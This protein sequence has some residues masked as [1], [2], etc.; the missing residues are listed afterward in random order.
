L[1]N[2]SDLREELSEVKEQIPV[3]AEPPD[4][5]Q[6][7]VTQEFIID[8][9]TVNPEGVLAWARFSNG[10]EQLVPTE[11]ISVDASPGTVIGAGE[12]V[13]AIE[14]YPIGNTS[15]S[16]VQFRVDLATSEGVTSD[17]SP[18]ADNPQ[19]DSDAPGLQAIDMSTLVPGPDESVSAELLPE[20]AARFRNVTGATVFGPD[21]TVLNSTIS[22]GDTVRFDTAG[23]GVYNVQTRYADTE[24]NTYEVPVTVQASS[25]SRTTGPTIRLAAG[26]AAGRYAVVGDGLVSG[27]VYT[28][29]TRGEL[30]VTATVS[31]GAPSTIHLW[32]QEV[33]IPPS[34]SLTFETVDTSGQAVDEGISVIM[35]APSLPEDALVWV[36]TESGNLEPLPEDG[37][38]YGS[39]TLQENQTLYQVRATSGSVTVQQSAN[40]G[41][42]ERIQYSVETALNGLPFL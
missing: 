37:N 17:T 31:D 20:D 1:E 8:G 42:I 32:A 28:E 18:V 30:G 23:A 22:D 2:I 5:G 25:T 3:D 11:Y 33:D 26:P 39:E 24:S 34:G 9:A 36:E 7:T 13:V 38:Q 41:W 27:D 21:G 14:D 4:V 10:T 19:V 40:P 12:T 15:A 16:A 35:H 29:A 6:E